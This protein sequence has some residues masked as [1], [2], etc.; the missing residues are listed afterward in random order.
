MEQ[1]T[2]SNALHIFE[3]DAD[4]TPLG[5]VQFC[6]FAEFGRKSTKTDP[7]DFDFQL[8]SSLACFLAYLLLIISYG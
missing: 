4:L 8:N 7:Q 1:E 3:F 2:R 6:F 5:E